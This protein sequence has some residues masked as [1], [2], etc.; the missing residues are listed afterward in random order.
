MERR[1]VLQ[2]LAVGGLAT[3]SPSLIGLAAEQPPAPGTI[4]TV[5]GTGQRGFSG[6]GG[7]ATKARLDSPQ[8]IAID[9]AGNV[10]IGDVA[11]N[12]VRRVSPDGIITTVA[13]TGVEGFSGD[14]GPATK[15]RLAGALYLA[16]DGAGNLYLSDWS[17]HRVRKVSP[18]GIITTVAGSGPTTS[19]APG[20]Y[21]GDGGP[22]TAA[23]LYYP[24]G[25]AV[26]AAGNLFIADTGNH[27]IRKVS[28]DGTITT[29]AGS[30]PT[31][32]DKG[33]STG[34]G[35]PALAATLRGPMCLAIDGAGNLFFTEKD[36]W[37]TPAAVGGYTGP[38]FQVRKVSADGIIRTVASN[39]VKGFS[40]DGGPA[41]AASLDNPLGVA[42]DTAGNLFIADWNNYRVRKVDGN[43]IISTVAG[44][45]KNPYA[46]DGVLAT[47]TGLRGPIAVAIDAAGNLVFTDTGQWADHE[48]DGLGL[49]D[50]RVLKVFGV[51]A[52]GLLAGMPFPAPR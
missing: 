32:P 12:R 33:A 9:A 10:F 28:P 3:L 49:L 41:L 14:G 25:L 35:G 2:L 6:D 27:R 17:H 39:G 19:E 46:G 31:G 24:E 51:A 11:N 15:A 36:P 1:I 20:D 23:R 47:T 43:G 22:A 45:G 29:V 37:G 50:E 30:G 44:T 21:A 52:P 34:D 8:G 48:T 4:A 38:R 26:D 40:G 5:A 18:D 42:V 16:L 7:P 13:G